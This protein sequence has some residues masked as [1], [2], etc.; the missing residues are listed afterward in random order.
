MEIA[1]PLKNTLTLNEYADVCIKQVPQLTCGI[2]R[3]TNHCYLCHKQYELMARL[4][5]NLWPVATMKFCPVEKKIDNLGTNV[6]QI[7]TEPYQKLP[8]E[9]YNF[10]KVAKF[11]QIWS[12]WPQDASKTSIQNYF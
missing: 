2:N 1:A 3:Y 7:L 4:F 10:A 8:K 11:R 5:Y 9:F 12:H 6:C